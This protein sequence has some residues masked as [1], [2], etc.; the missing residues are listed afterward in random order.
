[1]I[2]CC[3]FILKLTLLSKTIFVPPVS[4]AYCRLVL[5]SFI[6]VHLRAVVIFQRY[7]SLR[8]V[9]RATKKAS[10]CDILP[11]VVDL[12]RSRY[13]DH[14]KLVGYELAQLLKPY[15]LPPAG[16]HCHELAILLKI[17]P[18]DRKFL[19]FPREVTHFVIQN[20]NDFPLTL[21]SNCR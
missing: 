8:N 5:F 20:F 13:I 14:K 12:A 17:R 3:C 19:R 2:K 18:P 7:T 1:M 21:M 6:G 16:F 9:S 4:V 11:Y 15:S 10:W